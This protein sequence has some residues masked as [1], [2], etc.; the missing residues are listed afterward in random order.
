MIIIL[1]NFKLYKRLLITPEPVPEDSNDYRWKYFKGCLGALDGTYIPVRVPQQDIPRYRNRK[2]TVSVNVLAVCDHNMNFVFV[3]SGWEGSAADSRILRDAITR[4]NGLRVPN[5]CYYLCD[6]GYTNCNG[7]LAPYRGVRYH[8][9]EWDASRK[10][11]NYQEYFNLKHA[12][13]R[14][15]IERSFGILRARWGILRS[16]SYYLIKTQNRFIL[17]CCLLHNFIRK[18]MAVDPLEDEV[19][20]LFDDGEQIDGVDENDGF[21]DPVES[22]HAW[23]TRRDNMATEMFANYV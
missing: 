2:G 10:P 7:F 4:P 11:Q 5:G 21:I 23:T 20:E 14:N 12:S 17:G 8:L 19:P 3:L 22:S 18:H 6:G 16:N 13:A 1:Y 9:K 15:C